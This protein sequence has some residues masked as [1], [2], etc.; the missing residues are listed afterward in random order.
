MTKYMK[1]R[2]TD[3]IVKRFIQPGKGRRFDLQF[4]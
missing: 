1:F 2:R 4:N 3:I